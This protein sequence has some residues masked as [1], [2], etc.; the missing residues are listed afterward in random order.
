MSVLLSPEAARAYFPRGLLQ[1]EGSYRFAADSLLLAMFIRPG[2]AV[3]LLDIGTGCGVVALAALCA[4]PGIQAWGVEREH[5]LVL[6][7]REN[8]RK[9]G[10]AD[11]FH[12]LEG[13][14]VR[15]DLFAP[16]DGGV[17]KT[18]LPEASFDIA[19]ANPPFRRAGRGRLPPGLL[20]RRAL[21]EEEGTLAYFCRCAARALVPRGRFG[22]LYE[23][24]REDFLLATLREAGLAPV[25][26]Q[27]V[28]AR[29]ERKPFRVLAEA[30]RG[31]DSDQ[32][33]HLLREPDLVLH[34]TGGE[35]GAPALAFCPFLRSGS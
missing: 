4:Y 11:A 32:I 31:P 15:D 7:A 14:V 18:A 2:R 3:R 24:D 10:F 26:L 12:L 29:P 6:A 16:A 35:T 27:F 22:I 28:R 30:V 23:A 20:R 33:P 17:E 19:L 25:R 34:E 21:F 5:E 9:L 13:D 1:P 8:A